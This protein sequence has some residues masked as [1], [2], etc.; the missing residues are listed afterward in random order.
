[1]SN[2]HIGIVVSFGRLIPTKIIKLF[3][4]GMLNVHGSLLPKWRGAAPIIYSLINGDHQTGITIMKIKPKKFDTG[5]IVLQKQINISEH[6]TLPELYTKLAKLGADALT[7]IFEDLSQ[8]LQFTKPQNEVD[9]TYAPKITSSIALVKWDEM[10]AKIVYNLHRALLGLYPLSTK[11]QDKTVKLHDITIAEESI[12]RKLDGEMPGTVI[13][14][15]IS[16]ALI[17]KCAG[18]S[19][20]SVKKLIIQGKSVMKARDFNN[21]FIAGKKESK[22]F[23]S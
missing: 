8:A 6:E 22:I 14:D 4:L 3:P 18:N 2:F 13:Y 5:E 16:D 7:E 20:I 1:M 11:F 9:A 17:I 23:F 21:G 12:T 15:R 10:S 19:C